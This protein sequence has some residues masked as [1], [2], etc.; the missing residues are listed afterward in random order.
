ME[1]HARQKGGEKLSPDLVEHF[2]V[3]KASLA[4]C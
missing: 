3:K 1:D 4:M 2:D